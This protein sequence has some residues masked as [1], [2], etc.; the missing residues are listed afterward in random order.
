MQRTM[1]INNRLRMT[2]EIHTMKYEQRHWRQWSS[3]YRRSPWNGSF[4]RTSLT[5]RIKL[6]QI[7]GVTRVTYTHRSHTAECIGANIN[8]S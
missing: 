6:L 8:T 3:A 2:D 7:R 1:Q 4:R 5:A